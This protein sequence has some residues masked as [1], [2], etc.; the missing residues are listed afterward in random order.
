MLIIQGITDFASLEYNNKND[1]IRLNPITLK[2]TYIDEIIP[3]KLDLNA[4]YI[5]QQAVWLFKDYS[6]VLKTVPKSFNKF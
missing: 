6:E 1:F 5:Q 2:K 3:A 4:K